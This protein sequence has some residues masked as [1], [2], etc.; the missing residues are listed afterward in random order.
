MILPTDKMMNKTDE[1]NV[2]IIKQKPYE[3]S[4]QAC[5]EQTSKQASKE[6]NRT[7]IYI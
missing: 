5:S 6:T 4:E 1:N 2:D 7:Y 3:A